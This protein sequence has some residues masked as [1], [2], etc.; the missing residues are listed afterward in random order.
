MNHLVPS[1]QEK[2]E[3]LSHEEKLEDLSHQQ[4]V[5]ALSHQQEVKDL[6][7]QQEV[8]DLSHPARGER[9]KSPATSRAGVNVGLVTCCCDSTSAPQR[10]EGAIPGSLQSLGAQRRSPQNTVYGYI[11][12][13]VVY[14]PAAVFL[15]YFCY[16]S[17]LVHI[18]GSKNPVEI[19]M[20]KKVG[21]LTKGDSVEL[22]DN[23]EEYIAAQMNDFYLFMCSF[24]ASVCCLSFSKSSKIRSLPKTIFVALACAVVCSWL[25]GL[26]QVAYSRCTLSSF[27]MQD[28]KSVSL[29]S[30]FNQSVSF[31][32][33]SVENT[34][35]YETSI[36]NNAF[37]MPFFWSKGYVVGLCSTGSLI[38]SHFV[39]GHELAHIASGD[40]EKHSMTHRAY[41]TIGFIVRELL[42]GM[43][44]KKGKSLS[45][46]GRRLADELHKMVM[47]FAFPAVTS[48]FHSMEYRADVLLAVRVW[49]GGD[50]ELACKLLQGGRE[51]FGA[52]DDSSF[53]A[54]HPLSSERDMFQTV[55]Q[56]SI[57]CDSS[58]S[59]TIQESS[60]EELTLG[61]GEN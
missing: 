30:F 24:L 37:V 38:E 46:A 23:I 52:L 4:K 28:D 9:S 5:E 8:K 32:G 43:L 42:C 2:L 45:S 39:M 26:V 55:F 6:S 1:H 12:G 36:K 16:S 13:V 47:H 44:K 14:A 22:L 41:N 11:Q 48:A 19:F 61:V 17:F 3:A 18:G 58:V 57:G 35:L 15:I 59:G 34:A 20:S 51:F 27:N 31:L 56:S 54:S 7:H 40:L 21:T 49:I 50:P 53:T 60:E 10:A 33:L 29:L 25:Q